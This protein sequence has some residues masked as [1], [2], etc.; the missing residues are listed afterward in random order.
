MIRK[1]HNHTLQTNTQH[2]TIA[3]TRHQKDKQSK[4]TNFLLSIKMI[5]KLKRTQINAQQNM[6]QTRNPKM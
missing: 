3:V 6:E 5:A 2:R 4:A 1:Y